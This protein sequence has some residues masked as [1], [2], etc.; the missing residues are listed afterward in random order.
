LSFLARIVA[1]KRREIGERRAARPLASLRA[2]ARRGEVRDFYAAVS[3]GGAII[4]ELKART[5]TVASFAQSENLPALAATYAA[6]GAVAIS[7]VTDAARFGTSLEDVRAVRAAVP[8]PVVAKDFVIDPYQI[9]EACAAGADAVLLIVR[10]LGRDRLA[11]LLNLA[12]ELGMEALVETHDEDELRAAVDVGARLVG[13][14]NRDLDTMSVSLDTTRRLA[15]LAPRG[16]VVVAESGIR[17]RADVEDLA[18]H[19]AT[20]FLVGSSLLDAPDPAAKLREL[21]GH[22]V[23]RGLGRA[24]RARLER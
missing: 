10:L 12:R 3:P 17:S 4:A 21:A 7:I 2:E 20:A 13:I 5:P 8:L 19:G 23:S 11:E 9:V 16:V 6:N 1:D 18:R 15:P 24:Q 22:G 14:N